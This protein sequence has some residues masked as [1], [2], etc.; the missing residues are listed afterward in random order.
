MVETSALG[1]LA[2]ADGVPD[3]ARAWVEECRRGMVGLRA[4]EVRSGCE[5]QRASGAA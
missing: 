1:R 2:R 3:G 4:Y 5:R